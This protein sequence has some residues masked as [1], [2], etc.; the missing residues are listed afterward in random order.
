MD[1][2]DDLVLDNII[3]L[4][5]A[6]SRG[7][8]ACV[9]RRYKQA[10]RR[11]DRMH[12]ATVVVKEYT[13]HQRIKWIRSHA[14]SVLSCI[15]TKVPLHRLPVHDM[16][17]LRVLRLARINVNIRELL[18]IKHLPL[19]KLEMAH[20]TRCFYQIDRFQMSLLNH[21]PNISLSFD[22][23]W[24]AAVLNDLGCI[25]TLQ[26]RCRQ[27]NW[28]R[29][30]TVCI[31]S[32]GK[33]EHLSVICHNKPRIDASINKTGLRNL[34]FHCDTLRNATPVYRL[35]GPHTHTLQLHG[36]RAM[37]S[38]KSVFK[39]APHLRHVRISASD[40]QHHTKPPSSV[41]HL[42]IFTHTYTS[43]QSIPQPDS[44]ICPNLTMLTH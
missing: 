40:V 6:E 37:V 43:R 44:L 41:E 22:D 16:T 12:G 26:I 3:R 14:P 19:K 25:Q 36:Q 35:L 11:V 9:C 33:L 13:Y 29:Q 17:N 21:I 24:N 38:T 18:A 42:S 5:T 2:V 15:A 7:R 28:F 32:V 10:V 23:T 1:D 31:E 20:L 34:Y 8:L 30:S 4:C 39:M 27:G